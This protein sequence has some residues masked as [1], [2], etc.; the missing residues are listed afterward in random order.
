MNHS[1]AYARPVTGA[2][3]EPSSNNK[4]VALAD[5]RELA[6]V[7]ELERQ[8]VFGAL[9]DAEVWREIARAGLR[10]EHLLDPPSRRA[11]AALEKHYDAEEVAPDDDRLVAG[12]L[13][14]SNDDYDALGSVLPCGTRGVAQAVDA[15]L[16]RSTARRQR[17]IERLAGAALIDGDRARA[18][19]LLDRAARVPEPAVVWRSSADIFAPL[20]E[21]PWRVP[22]LQIGPGRP[23]IVA[24]FG[25]SAKTL[26]VQALALACAAGG[27]VWDHFPVRPMVVRHLDYEQGFHATAKRYQRLALGMGIEPWL[28]DGKLALADL[29]SIYL[30]DS[31][32][33]DA[34]AR[35][36]DGADLVVI[37]ALRGATPR[38]DENDSAIRSCIDAL[39]RASS[40]TGAAFVLIHHSNKPPS[41]GGD[42]DQ[43]MTLR[44]SGAIFDGAGC[45]LTISAGK[46]PN[47]A[48]LVHNA[49]PSAAA[50]ST[51]EDFEL[52]VEDVPVG[53]DARGGVRVV[54]R[55]VEAGEA[56]RQA[57]EGRAADHAF[58]ALKE[59]VLSIV[60][61]NPGA[62][63]SR[64]ARLAQARKS[65]VLDALDELCDA[66]RLVP[67]R[68]QGRQVM[69]HAEGSGGPS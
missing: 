3:L 52:L 45:V 42:R 19:E 22:G 5:R 23:T 38:V 51:I 61:T 48:R 26:S 16:E 35:V 4:V 49:K 25:A 39:T 33:A 67:I 56:V 13:G 34:F 66:G 44:G 12:A 55:S 65:A 57:A 14:I 20:P 40:L 17:E 63:N 64:I 27:L 24:G 30:S 60:R 53:Q 1:A 10:Y 69:Y 41:G 28:V 29:P 36:A 21:T 59:R 37:D 9:L 8:L 54:H 18:E 50:A 43:R 6:L 62:N 15:L 46:E 31:D 68:G 58:G 2:S 32:A 7:A 47:D 11:W